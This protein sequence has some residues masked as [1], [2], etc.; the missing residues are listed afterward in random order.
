MKLP[1]DTAKEFQ[2]SAKLKGGPIFYFG[3]YGNI[4]FSKLTPKRAGELVAAGFPH[5]RKKKT[6]PKETDKE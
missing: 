4:D 1:A 5:L 6:K 2:L 3:I